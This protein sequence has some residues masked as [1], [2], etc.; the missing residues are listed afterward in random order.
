MLKTNDEILDDIG[1]RLLSG[2]LNYRELAESAG[3]SYSF[4][5]DTILGR[6]SVSDKL[7]RALGYR[8]VVRFEPLETPDAK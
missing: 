8:K 6:K 4:V 1:D 2:V 3:V 5:R 7:A